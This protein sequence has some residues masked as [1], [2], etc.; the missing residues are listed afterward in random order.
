[1]DF[2]SEGSRRVA[3][4]PNRVQV[5]DTLK[6]LKTICTSGTYSLRSNKRWDS[7]DAERCVSA[8][9]VGRK[10]FLFV[11]S[12]RAGHAAANYYSLVESCKANRVSPLTYLTDILSHARDRALQ[13]Q[14]PDRF[15]NLSAA[16]AGGCVC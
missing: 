3:K 15:S 10:A 13:L 7:S 2:S 4:R 12:E 8:V 6:R 11:V 14:T 16:P 1:M 9:A 5:G